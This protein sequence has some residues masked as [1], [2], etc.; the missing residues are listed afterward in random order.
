MTRHC[1]MHITTAPEEKKVLAERL[2]EIFPHA[3]AA[4]IIARF[5]WLHHVIACI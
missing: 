1:T 4:S 2:Q 3:T 5:G